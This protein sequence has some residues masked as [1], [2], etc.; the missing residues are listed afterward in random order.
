[1]KTELILK[2][3]VLDIIFEKRNKNYGAYALRKFYNN[4][5]YKA[6]GLTLLLAIL[7]CSFTLITPIKKII[8]METGKT[9]EF[10]E[11]NTKDKKKDKP[12][13]KVQEKKPIDA[14]NKVPSTI[15]TQPKITIKTNV[16]ALTNITPSVVIASVNIVVPS[17]VELKVGQLPSVGKDSGSISPITKTVVDNVTPLISADVMPAYPGGMIELNKFLQNNLTNPQDLEEGEKISV[18]IKFIVG[19][20]GKL[21]GFETVEDGGTAFNNEVIRVLKKMPAWIPGK[22]NGDNVSVYFTVPVKFISEN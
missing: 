5:L 15:F 13:E 2:A 7:L 19:Y 22:M 1:M 14:Q 6:L 21:K 10:A 16:A 11:V 20:D 12:I 3:D 17:G 9:V 18:K 4:R 8:I